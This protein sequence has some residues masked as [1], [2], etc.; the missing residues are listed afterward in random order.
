MRRILFLIGLWLAVFPVLAEAA[1]VVLSYDSSKP[2]IAFA[3]G[4]IRKA[5]AH[6]GHTFRATPLAEI[7]TTTSDLRI[8]LATLEDHQALDRHARDGGVTPSG[9]EAQGFALRTTENPTKAFWV[10]A[11]CQSIVESN[12]T[13]AIPTSGAHIKTVF[14][15]SCGIRISLPT[16]FTTS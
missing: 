1:H 13:P 12:S 3:A 11:I 5:L 4:D 6:H 7:E 2:Q 16:N 14:W 9:L 15:A 8:V 10:I